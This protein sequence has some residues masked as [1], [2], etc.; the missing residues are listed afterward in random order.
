MK[1]LEKIIRRFKSIYPESPRLTYS[2]DCEDLIVEKIIKKNNGFYVDIGAHDPIKHSNTYLLYKKGWS[3]INIDANPMAIA[4]FNK[5][6]KNCINLNVGI[7]DVEGEFSFY[8]SENPL[9]SSFDKDKVIEAKTKWNFSFSTKNIRTRRLENVLNDYVKNNV[10]IDLFNIDVEGLELEILKSNDW[11]KY[12]PKIIIIELHERYVENVIK[13]EIYS[14]LYLKGY[15][16]VSKTFIT[17]I[18][19]RIE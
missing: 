14:F 8:I 12:L 5:K 9:L 3:G 1:L 19:E 11:N 16:L 13:S 2:Y 17:L 4:M 18:F 6:R 10:E 7:S 15:R